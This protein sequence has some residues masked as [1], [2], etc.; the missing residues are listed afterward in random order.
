MH[1][2]VFPTVALHCPCILI[3]MNE[4]VIHRLHSLLRS[5]HIHFFKSFIWV[6]IV[7]GDMHADAATFKMARVPHIS[8]CDHV[9]DK[10]STCTM[11]MTFQRKILIIMAANSS[12]PVYSPSPCDRF[13]Y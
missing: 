3:L 7:I 12:E 13:V 6:G 2:H 9:T 4:Y 11:Y 8:F 1:L 10:Q 5:C